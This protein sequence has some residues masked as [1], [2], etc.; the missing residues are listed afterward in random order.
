MAAAEV[1][2]EALRNF[3][4]RLSEHGIHVH[5]D[6]SPDLPFV[7]VDQRAM[8]LAV[9]NLID[10][11]IR[12]ARDQGQIFILIG[13]IG[14]VVSIEVRDD[15]G[16]ISEAKLA[17]LRESI[18]SRAFAKSDGGGLGLAIVS[19]VVADHR[20]TFTVDSELGTGTRCTIGLPA[21]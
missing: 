5:F 13:R 7:R 17:A 6:M 9:S 8:M 15:G 14:S 16:G 19:T 21:C 3:Q 1:V 12:H 20:G 4:P 10:N 11:A 2:Y 18:A